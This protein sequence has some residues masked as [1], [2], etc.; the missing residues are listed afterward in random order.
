MLSVEKGETTARE[1]AWAREGKGLGE[2]ND[3]GD[4]YIEVDMAP[5][6]CGRIRMELL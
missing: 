1:P 2:N 4:T 3:L 5:S 6:I